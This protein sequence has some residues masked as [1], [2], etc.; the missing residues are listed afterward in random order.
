MYSSK[1][2]RLLQKNN[3]CAPVMNNTQK[4][5]KKQTQKHSKNGLLSNLQNN[6]QVI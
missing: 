4:K 1:E 3:P 2:I 5:L 6:S